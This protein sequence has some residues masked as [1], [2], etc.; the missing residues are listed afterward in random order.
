MNDVKLSFEA[1]DIVGQVMSFGSPTP[2]RGDHHRQ[3]RRQ[4]TAA[5]AAKVKEQ[6][7]QIPSLSAT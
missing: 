7:A 3:G 1:S 2:G 4:Q 6:L 5:Y